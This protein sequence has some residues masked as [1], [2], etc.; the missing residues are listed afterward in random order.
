MIRLTRLSLTLGTF[1]LIR[2]TQIGG[3]VM[4]QYD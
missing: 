4:P 2:T 1:R 3:E